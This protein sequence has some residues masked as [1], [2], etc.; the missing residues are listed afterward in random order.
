M[1]TDTVSNTNFN[2]NTAVKAT[3]GASLFREQFYNK[4]N[5]PTQFKQLLTD[6]YGTSH[7]TVAAESLHQ[8]ALQS[9]VSWLPEVDYLPA[10]E[11]NGRLG[12]YNP[13]TDTVYISDDLR[14]TPA[15][16]Q[17]F[18]EEVELQIDSRVNSVDTQ[19]DEGD[20]FSANLQ[21][22]K[23]STQQLREIWLEN[24][25]CHLNV[26]GQMIAAEIRGSA[27]V[28]DVDIDA[29]VQAVPA[30]IQRAHPGN[31]EEHIQRI[32]SV[33][34]REGLSQ[35]QT[36]YVLA[37]ATHESHLGRYMEELASGSAYEGRTDLGNTQ[38]GDGVR[39]KG[40][41]YVQITGRANYQ[42]W[43]NRLGID[44]V[45]NPEL[46][47]NPE[48][49]AEILVIGMRDGSFTGRSLDQYVNE[50]GTDFINARRVVNGTDVADLI[51][52]YANDFNTN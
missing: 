38:P 5:D 13:N 31:I 50:S 12:A 29:I 14:G 27:P 52:G 51:A 17:V 45:A 19:G 3:D 42:D 7:N 28:G 15:A 6:T 22:K 32:V 47:E 49:A 41:G 24:D 18:I 20:Q 39:F 21:G 37:T 8:Q 9:D 43:S 10:G 4:A 2:R 46:A 1:R 35:Q 40:R 11:F 48:I 34:Q 33:A 25:H 30:D 44:L 26:E 16:H 23:L 36:A